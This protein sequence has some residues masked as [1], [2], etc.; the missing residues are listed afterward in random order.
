MSRGLGGGGERFR[1]S[2]RGG[3]ERGGEVAKGSW[4]RGGEQAGGIE[5]SL[6]VVV[7][8]LGG[9][10]DLLA[11]LWTDRMTPVSSPSCQSQ[12]E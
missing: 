1:G 6:R 4:R 11:L 5:G 2:R 9:K 7:H 8:Q 10:P 3:T 12:T